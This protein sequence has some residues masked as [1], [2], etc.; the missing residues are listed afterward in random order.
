MEIFIA[1]EFQFFKIFINIIHSIALYNPI[2]YELAKSFQI[3]K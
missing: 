1:K 2:I 3:L